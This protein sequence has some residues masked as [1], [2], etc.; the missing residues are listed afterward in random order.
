MIG[1]DA[2]DDGS[3]SLMIIWYTDIASKIVT[4]ANVYNYPV[5]LLWAYVQA[6]PSSSLCAIL[7]RR[8][9]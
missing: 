8:I 1:T 6:L 4:A 7:I 2:E 5:K 3:L 9:T